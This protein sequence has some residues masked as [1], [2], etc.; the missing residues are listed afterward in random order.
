[1]D[2]IVYRGFTHDIKRPDCVTGRKILVCMTNYQRGVYF[3]WRNLFV[4]KQ[5]FPRP[6]EVA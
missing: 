2:I 4:A 6:Y 5:I 1:M 3:R